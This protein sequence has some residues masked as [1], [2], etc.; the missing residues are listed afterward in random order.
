MIDD[1]K[2]SIKRTM[3]E[4]LKPIPQHTCSWLKGKMKLF[5]YQGFWNCI[6]SVP[7]ALILEQ[8][9][10]T[11]LAILDVKDTSNNIKKQ[12]NECSYPVWVGVPENASEVGL[13][14]TVLGEGT[15]R[16]PW[17]FQLRVP[18]P[19]YLVLPTPL[20]WLVGVL[21]TWRGDVALAYAIVT[22]EKF[23]ASS[24]PLLTALP[25]D[26]VLSLQMD[27]KT[28]FDHPI[29]ASYLPYTCLS[30]SIIS[31]NCKSVY[32][33][34]V[35][36]IR[37]CIYKNTKDVIVSYYHY[38]REMVNLHVEDAP[39]EVALD[40]Y[41][42]RCYKKCKEAC[43]SEFVGH[44]FL[45]EEEKAGVVE[46]IINLCSF[47]NLSNLQVNKSGTQHRNEHFC[48]D[49]RFGKIGDWE[50]YFTDDMKEN[51]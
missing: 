4:V 37:H 34:T 50:N 36:D 16:R 25:H 44:H 14:D 7:K 2:L 28:S 19:R 31:S 9:N 27:R 26:C 40:E 35:A 5:K 30:E 48:V 45:V 43:R 23:N 18:A 21:V 6:I 1:S 13:E 29:I 39:F 33:Y 12:A 10:S 46:N 38:A 42:K 22:R 3:E 32:I 51:I 8:L 47:E 17:R 41:E 11:E 15:P 49:N 24:S 20:I